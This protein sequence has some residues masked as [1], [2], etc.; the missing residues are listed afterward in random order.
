MSKL[1]R[2]RK[3]VI[4]LKECC[5]WCHYFYDGKCYKENVSY[6]DDKIY[7]VSEDGHLLDTI[8]EFFNEIKLDEFK[9]LENKLREWKLSEKKIK[10]FNTLFR[11]CFDMWSFNHKEE[12]DDQIT[13]CYHNNVTDE[14][15]VLINNPEEYCCKD[16]C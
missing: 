10:E 11:Q 5:R 14:K 8:E 15:G 7:K 4:E 12:L 9:K 13:L 1:K 6:E 16:W 2:V 3:N